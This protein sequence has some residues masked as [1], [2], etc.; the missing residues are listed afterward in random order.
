M[1]LLVA[2]P[3][4]PAEHSTTLVKEQRGKP[5]IY[6]IDKTQPIPGKNNEMF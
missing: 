1:Q 6:A 3:Q 4:I 5:Q 2:K